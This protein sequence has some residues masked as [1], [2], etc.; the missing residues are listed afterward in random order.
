MNEGRKINITKEME[1]ALYHLIALDYCESKLVAAKKEV[2]ELTKTSNKDPTKYEKAYK[3]LNYITSMFQSLF[4]EHA[5]K[6]IGHIE[7]T[8]PTENNAF[9]QDK[10][11][12]CML[13]RK[14]PRW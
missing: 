9:D 12:E 3:K 10:E 4:R 11:N 6:A 14:E 1:W 2:Y 8:L 5:K 13:F 7:K